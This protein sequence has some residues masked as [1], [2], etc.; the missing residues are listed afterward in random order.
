VSA[1]GW[2][3][4]GAT[5][6]TQGKPRGTPWLVV[7]VDVVVYVA[8]FRVLAGFTTSGFHMTGMVPLRGL[9]RSFVHPGPYGHGTRQRTGS[10]STNRPTGVRLTNGWPGFGPHGKHT[11]PGLGAFQNAK[12]RFKANGSMYVCDHRTGAEVP[13]GVARA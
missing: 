2:R 1:S 11:R 12:G 10:G 9:G 7:G 5:W 4:K 8:W 6:P 13:C 3:K